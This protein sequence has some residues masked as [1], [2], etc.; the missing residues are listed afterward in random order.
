LGITLELK[1]HLNP[2]ENLFEKFI[3]D[4]FVMV[5]GYVSRCIP[6][7]SVNV[8]VLLH[9]LSWVHNLPVSKPMRTAAYSDPRLCTVTCGDLYSKLSSYKEMVE[10]VNEFFDLAGS[11]NETWFLNPGAGRLKDE[12]TTVADGIVPPHAT[13]KTLF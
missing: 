10:E 13:C 8:L 11:R 2:S 5:M 6:A 3:F 4:Q 1:A 7:N 12:M 9:A